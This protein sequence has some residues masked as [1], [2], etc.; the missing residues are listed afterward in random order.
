MNSAGDASRLTEIS[1]TL[2]GTAAAAPTAPGQ[3]AVANQRNNSILVSFAPSTDAVATET[4]LS[5]LLYVD[6]RLV[7]PTCFQYCFGVTG[8]TATR[9]APGTSYRIGVAAVN[10]TGVV[11]DVAEIGAST[12]A[13]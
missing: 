10:L 7:G 11:S 8:A 12:L 1:V 5:Y 13:P 4:Q 9:L 3:L 6:G 2:P